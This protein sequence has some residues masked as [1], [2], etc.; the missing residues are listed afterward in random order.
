[1]QIVFNG[2]VRKIP[3]CNWQY[4]CDLDTF[5]KWYSSWEIEDPN[6]ECGIV[7]QYEKDLED[8]YIN[9]NKLYA[10]IVILFIGVILLGLYIW[11]LKKQM[12][13]SRNAV[14]TGETPKMNG[15]GYIENFEEK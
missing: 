15:D 9:K 13:A 4:T 7:D 5:F 14:H 12:N 3:F 8:E 6:A 2:E 1:M 11:W 10:A